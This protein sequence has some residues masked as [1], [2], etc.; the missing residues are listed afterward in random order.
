MRAL[1]SPA[2]ARWLAGLLTPPR[3]REFV[4][5]DLEELYALRRE[6]D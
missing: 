6:R 3:E 2:L 4:L 5:G 1:R